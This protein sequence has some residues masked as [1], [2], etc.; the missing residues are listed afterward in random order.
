MTD[1]SFPRRLVEVA[2]Q[3]GRAD[4][5]AILPPLV[6]GLRHRWSL[7]VGRPFEPGGQAA[8]VAPARTGD[9]ADVVLKLSWRHDEAEH[10]ADG[11]GAWAGDGGVRLHAAEEHPDTLVLLIER[12]QPGTPLSERPGTEQD[13]VVAGLLRRL[14]REPPA[15]HRFR[16]LQSMCDTWADE[17]EQK[18]AVRGATLD[19]G[20]ASEGIELFRSLPSSADRRVLLATDLHAGNVLAAEREPWLAIDP[21]PYVGDPAYDVLQHL[22][23]DAERLQADPRDL[24]WRLCDLAGLDR[25]RVVRWLFARCVMESPGRP[26]LADV[27]RRLGA[28]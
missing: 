8:W 14:W 6:H 17:F 20:L 11:L 15:G 3:Q 19:P 24:A 18:V 7:A 4:W 2:Q 23:N 25:E 27:A 10:E 1:L 26:D 21:K 12:C 5:L 28:G 9:G 22:L 13:A 16:S